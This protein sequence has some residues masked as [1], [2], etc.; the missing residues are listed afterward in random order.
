MASNTNIQITELDFS[1]I[2]NSFI[3]YLQ[4]QDNFKDYNFQGSALS[5]LLDVLAYNTQYN[6]Y[7]LNMVANEMFLD[8]ALQRASVVSHAKLLNYT[9]KSAIAP[10]ATINFTANGVAPNEA[11]TLPRFTNFLSEAIDGVNYNF[12]TTESTTINNNNDTTVTFSNIELKQGIPTTYRYVLNTT[13][14]PKALFEIPDATI[15]TT[16]LNVFVQQNN[17]NTNYDVYQ[18]ASNYLELNSNSLVYFLQ[19]SL[20]G[21]YEI[22]FGDGVL[23]KKLDNENVI[24][25]SY[26][27]TNGTS[28]SGANNFVLMDSIPGMTSSSIDPVVPASQ[29]GAKESIS[30]IKFQAPK[31]YSAQNRAVTKED[32]ITILQQNTLGI[33]FDAVNV[34]GGEQNDPP[35]YGQVFIAL[36]PSGGYSLTATQKQRLISEVIKPISVLTVEPNIVDPDYTYLNISASVYYDPNKTSQTPLQ[37]ESGIKSS[38]TTFAKNNLNTFNSTFSSYDLLSSIQNYSS[39]I[40]SSDFSI[41]L[42]KKFYP[43]LTSSSSYNLYFGTQLEKGVLQSGVTS[44]PSMQFQDPTNLAIIIDGVYVEEVPQL[45]NGVESISILN[46][47][48]SYQ[49]TPTITILGDGSGA[50]AHAIIVSGRIS[51]I[52]VDSAGSGYTDAIAVVTPNVNDTTG[53]FG[54][55][56]VNL[57][58][59]FGTLRTYYNNS[60]NVKTILNANAGTIDYMNGIVTLTNFSPYQINNDLGAL[61]ISAKP[62][63]TII[64]STYNR[65]IS[66][67]EFDSYSVSVKA[68]AKSGK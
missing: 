28:A 13:S 42:Q 68:I 54:S 22:Y 24:V 20:T 39:S 4:G 9:P 11:F 61:T 64:S 56:V 10:S 15:D 55:L 26:I 37:L 49:Y 60:T 40:I 46:P 48:Y 52:V 36:K 7:Y 2:K 3:Q 23:G 67:D 47:G 5:T 12:V 43:S 63:T 32:Y 30:S 45:S 38:I 25:L 27:S 34:W 51:K 65:I 16:T 31:S 41:K 18:S 66:V 35:V 6:A 21:T 62:T 33:S 53:Q 44:F 58:G 17:A 8:S 19:E 59:R 14:N 50:T 57:D 29:G 1:N